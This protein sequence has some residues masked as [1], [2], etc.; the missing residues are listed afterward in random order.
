MKVEIL[1]A[2]TDNYMYLL[3]DQDTREAAIVDPVQPQKVTRALALSCASSLLWP[4]GKEL[5]RVCP[6]FQGLLCP[7]LTPGIADLL[8]HFALNLI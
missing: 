5:P 3:I 8:W 6:S 4:G 2:L 1:P 7:S